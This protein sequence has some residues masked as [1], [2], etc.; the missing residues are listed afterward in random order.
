[1]RCRGARARPAPGCVRS[2]SE[3]DMPMM[4]SL[5]GV[6]V[7]MGLTPPSADTLDRLTELVMLARSRTLG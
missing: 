4:L 1:M 2:H 6:E 5:L 3:R 7:A